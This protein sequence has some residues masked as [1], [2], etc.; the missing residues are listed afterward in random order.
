MSTHV[1]TL[2]MTDASERME[3]RASDPA[4]TR[5]GTSELNA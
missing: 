2:Q 5:K 1:A 3:R 4:A